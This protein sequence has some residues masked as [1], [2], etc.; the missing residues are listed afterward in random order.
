MPEIIT[1][2]DSLR[3]VSKPVQLVDPK[4]LKK[5]DFKPLDL[6]SRETET[7]INDLLSV[8]PEDGLGLAAPQIGVFERV[9]VAKLSMGKFIF[10]NPQI[11]GSYATFV[12]SEGC[13]SLPGIHKFV[14]R[15]ISVSVKADVIYK[16]I[17]FPLAHEPNQIESIVPSFNTAYTSDAAILQHE[18]DHLEGVLLMD[19]PEPTAEQH[20]IV[21]K[22]SDRKKRITS[23]RQLR[24]AKLQHKASK[25]ITTMNPK[26]REERDKMFKSFLKKYIKEQEIQAALEKGT[27]ESGT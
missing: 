3:V 8:L 12:S 18:Y 22:E 23:K 16:V 19:Y 26:K 13:L 9:F 14:N 5:D 27:I 2:I 4:T 7:L 15:A 21:K 6:V 11:T 25:Q 10:I 1:D 20:A 24:K 17:S